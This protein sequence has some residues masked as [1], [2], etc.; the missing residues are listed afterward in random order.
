MKTRIYAAPAVKGLKGKLCLSL[1]IFQLFIRNCTWRLH[2]I[3]AGEGW[4][5]E[6]SNIAGNLVGR[7]RHRTCVLKFFRRFKQVFSCLWTNS[8]RSGHSQSRTNSPHIDVAH[9]AYVA[10]ANKYIVANFSCI[11]SKCRSNYVTYQ[12]KN[13]WNVSKYIY[14]RQ[15]DVILTIAHQIKSRVTI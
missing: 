9:V 6:I 7:W 8:R 13:H 3:S 11:L 2:V 15:D 14:S 1:F 4:K 10:P 12:L 5:R